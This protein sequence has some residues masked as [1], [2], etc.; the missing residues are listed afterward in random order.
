[1]LLTILWFFF[2]NFRMS[3]EIHLTKKYNEYSVNL[4]QTPRLA[5]IGSRRFDTTYWLHLQGYKFPIILLEYFEPSKITDFSMTR[6]HMPEER[7]LSYTTKQIFKLNE[8]KRLRIT[9]SKVCNSDGW[10][11]EWLWCNFVSVST[12]ILRFEK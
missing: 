6:F 12:S 2:T 5:L 9:F 11:R 3:E 7:S 8:K 4:G 1:M 10:R